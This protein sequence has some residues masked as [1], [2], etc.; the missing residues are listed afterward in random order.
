MEKSQRKICS[1][2]VEAFK[3][4][5][6]AIKPH[7]Y[8]A[9]AIFYTMSLIV[10]KHGFSALT[11]HEQGQITAILQQATSDTSLHT[12]RDIFK[13]YVRLHY[14]DAFPIKRFIFNATQVL[15]KQNLQSSWPRKSKIY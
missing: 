11:R 5:I 15:V 12:Y 8:N 7:Q 10:G 1:G 6:K 4:A 13:A 14:P 2:F 3:Q 9:F